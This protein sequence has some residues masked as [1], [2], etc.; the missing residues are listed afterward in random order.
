M[1]LKRQVAFFFGFVFYYTGFLDLTRFLR[2]AVLKKRRNI[3]LL[4][5]NVLNPASCQDDYAVSRYSFEGQIRYLIAK[6][7]R[8]ISLEGMIA[9]MRS[10]NGFRGDTL[11]LTFDDGYE[12]HSSR[13]LPILKKYKIP[14]VFFVALQSIGG[15]D[16]LNWEQLRQ[17]SAD[18][19]EIGSHTLSHPYLSRLSNRESIQRE[20]SESRKV[21]EEK[22][23]T[24]IRYFAYPYADYDNLTVE[25]VKEAGY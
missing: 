2:R 10:G 14:A 1:S 9:A 17:M 12:S 21:L 23:K 4:Y 24:K 3:I 19:F 16:H 6:G 11:A 15:K 7:Y 13:V 18:G 25:A 8:V 22:I 5:H 20:V